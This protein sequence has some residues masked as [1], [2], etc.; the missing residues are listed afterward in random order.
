MDLNR[1]LKLVREGKIDLEDKDTL[2]SKEFKE[3]IESIS[4]VLYEKLNIEQDPISILLDETNSEEVAY[5][6]KDT[7]YINLGSK[8]IKE[9]KN[10]KLKLI[11]GYYAHEIGH[12]LFTNFSIRQTYKDSI[13]NNS[14]YPNLPKFEDEKLNEN[15][16]K[17]DKYIK[18]PKKSGK[19][20][21]I[22]LFVY[23]VIEDSRIEDHMYKNL[24][25]YGRLIDGLNILRQNQ[26]NSIKSYNEDLL[27]NDRFYALINQIICYIKFGKFKGLNLNDFKNLKEAKS[28]IDKAI[29]EESDIKVLD[30]VNKIVMFLWNE[31][32]PYLEKFTDSYKED[33]TSIKSLPS[34]EVEKDLCE[35]GES[36][37]TIGQ[38]DTKGEAKEKIKEENIK[39]EEAKDIEINKGLVKPENIDNIKINA[40]GD[41]EYKS[42]LAQDKNALKLENT[43]KENNLSSDKMDKESEA[44]FS[45]EACDRNSSGEGKFNFNLSKT[46]FYGDIHKDIKVSFHR[47]EFTYD[48]K[49]N[50]LNDNKKYI[51][52]AHELAKQVLPLLENEVTS[53][54]SKNRY[55]GT[56]FNASD[57]SKKDFRYF[58]K[59]NPPNESPS[60][61]VA[62]RIDESGSMKANN[63]IEIAR[64]TAILIWEFCKKCEIPIGV[65]GDTADISALEDVSIYSYSDFDIKDKNDCYRMMNM[66]PKSN[67]RDGVSI[68]F[69]AEKLLKV[70]S[71]IKV[72]FIISDGKPLAMPNYKDALAKDDL[73]KIVSEYSRK[74]INFFAASIGNDREVIRDIYG[75]NRFLDISNLNTLPNR[76]AIILKNLV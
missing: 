45:G 43:N 6:K 7:I 9:E 26:Y 13:L 44:I 37:S 25:N 73:K 4:R 57:V 49:L 1:V 62:L 8:S 40:D 24:S 36:V 65:Y 23:D 15:I 54:Y 5:I 17:M 46:I 31:I 38:T 10:N 28:I 66:S 74:G 70:D 32:E 33:L 22:L 3:Y 30:K 58:S 42:T 21:S 2:K 53:E 71:D 29:S 55:Y 60:I 41:S 12:R 19:L 34:F 61:A 75:D 48:D 59:K 68:K 20:C 35:N 52:A 39:K 18:D 16:I 50:Y 11:L 64:A 76:I 47:P 63:R 14:W 56:K 51:K 72:L 69:V 67:N 27:N